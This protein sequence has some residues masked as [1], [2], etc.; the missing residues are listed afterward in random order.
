M[1]GRFGMHT[2][3]VKHALMHP[4]ELVNISKY[5]QILDEI[6]L[7]RLYLVTLALSQPNPIIGGKIDSKI[8]KFLEG[9]PGETNVAIAAAVSGTSF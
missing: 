5:Y 9:V 2:E 4:K 6:P 7:G 8:Q 3:A 1:Y